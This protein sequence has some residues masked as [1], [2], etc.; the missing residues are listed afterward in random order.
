MI[1]QIL[2]LYTWIMVKASQDSVPTSLLVLSP[3]HATA[4]I[5][6]NN[7]RGNV[8][9][10][11]KQLWAQLPLP[12]NTAFATRGTAPL[13]RQPSEP[14]STC[15]LLSLR[16]TPPPLRTCRATSC[17]QPSLRMP[18]VGPSPPSPL[19]SL[20]GHVHP[21]HSK[22]WLNPVLFGFVNTLLELLSNQTRAPASLC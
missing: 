7:L 14:P 19:S 16:P 8:T 22:S 20:L 10:I 13:T 15:R 9:S 6:V 4:R 21:L 2:S 11:F 12:G 5:T 17:P 1:L 3:L 18:P